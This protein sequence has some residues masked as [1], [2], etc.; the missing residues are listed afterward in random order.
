MVGALGAELAA[1]FNRALLTALTVLD[2]V[3]VL[4]GMCRRGGNVHDQ[5]LCCHKYLSH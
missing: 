4:I 3:V 2:A 1:A 5:A